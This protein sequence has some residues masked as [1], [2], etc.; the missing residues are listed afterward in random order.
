M[1]F[2]LVI[3]IR[4]FGIIILGIS[5]DAALLSAQTT[6]LHPVGRRGVP[7]D[8]AQ[9]ALFLATSASSF[10]TGTQIVVDGGLTIRAHP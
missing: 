9:A 1:R 8:V 3:L 6:A 7:H 2:A 4:A 5:P 10:V